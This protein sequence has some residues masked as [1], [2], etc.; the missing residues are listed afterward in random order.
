MIR[1]RGIACNPWAMA[2]PARPARE[3]QLVAAAAVIV[4]SDDPGRCDQSVARLIAERVVA[5]A[6]EDLQ[7]ADSFAVA[8]AE[9]ERS[10]A[11]SP[12]VE[13]ARDPTIDTSAEITRRRLERFAARCCSQLAEREWETETRDIAAEAIVTL[14]N[15]YFRH[16]RRQN[17]FQRAA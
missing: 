4:R 11:P 12:I 7:R 9:L 2:R 16:L 3:A 13:L 14:A 8:L 15:R 10:L 6:L 1:P 17:N 5:A